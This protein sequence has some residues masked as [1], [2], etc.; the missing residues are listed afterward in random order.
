MFAVF[1]SVHASCQLGS[2]PSPSRETSGRGEQQSSAQ[3]RMQSFNVT[4]DAFS[5]HY[6]RANVKMLCF[7]VVA[8]VKFKQI[9]AIGSRAAPMHFYTNIIFVSTYYMFNQYGQVQQSC[10]CRCCVQC[11]CIRCTLFG[12]EMVLYQFLLFR[13]KHVKFLSKITGFVKQS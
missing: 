6:I 4:C 5:E 12:Q 10:H 8:G 13:V 2:P 1:A 7:V 3:P 9:R 11:S